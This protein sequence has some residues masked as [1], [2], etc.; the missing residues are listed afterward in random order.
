MSRPKLIIKVSEGIIPKKIDSFGDYEWSFYHEVGFALEKKGL[1][2][3]D[4]IGK[5]IGISFKVGC[6]RK[7]K[8]Y[9]FQSFKQVVRCE[10][11]GPMTVIF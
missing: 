3:E 10:C 11:C 6:R 4:I 8:S 2:I 9:R 1:T 5:K 7:L